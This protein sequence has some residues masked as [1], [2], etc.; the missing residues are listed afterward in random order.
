MYGKDPCEAKYQLLIHKW[1]S[2][3][4]KHFNVPKAFINYSND[5]QDL[6]TDIID[7]NKDKEHK[8]FDSFWWYDC[9]YD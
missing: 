7:Y 9:W 1:E 5:I 6:Y 3:R 2:T 4:L 8:N